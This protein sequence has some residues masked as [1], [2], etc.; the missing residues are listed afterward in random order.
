MMEAELLL[1]IQ[2]SECEITPETK[3]QKQEGAG[4]FGSMGVLSDHRATWSGHTPNRSGCWIRGMRG[5]VARPFLQ[6]LAPMLAV[7]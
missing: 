2:K 7:L 6:T 4:W 3:V 5:D 1:F